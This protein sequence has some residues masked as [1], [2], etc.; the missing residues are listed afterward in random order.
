MFWGKKNPICFWHGVLNFHLFCTH[1]SNN[2]KNRGGIRWY[3]SQAS[4]NILA[5]LAHITTKRAHKVPDDLA[6]QDKLTK[7]ES[8]QSLIP[9]PPRL[10][11]H[12]LLYVVLQL[13]LHRRGGKL[14]RSCCVQL[15]RRSGSLQLPVFTPLFCVMMLSTLLFKGKA[16]ITFKNY[17]CDWNSVELPLVMDQKVQNALKKSRWKSYFFSRRKKPAWQIGLCFVPRHHFHSG[18]RRK[19]PTNQKMY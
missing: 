14:D 8:C 7:E 1:A 12:F 5:W 17:D 4:A 10:K 15:F 2:W 18:R 16:K 19:N 11:T 13:K 9:L 6:S 3:V